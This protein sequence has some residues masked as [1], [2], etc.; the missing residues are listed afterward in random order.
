[1]SNPRIPTINIYEYDE[2]AELIDNGINDGKERDL[3]ASRYGLIGIER[4]VSSAKRGSSGVGYPDI[5]TIIGQD[6]G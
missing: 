1:M 6:Q 5:V 3:D 2:L 4:E